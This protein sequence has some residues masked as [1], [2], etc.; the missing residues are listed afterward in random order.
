[1]KWLKKDPLSKIAIKYKLPLSFVALYLIVFGAGGYFIINSVNDSFDRE[2]RA[3]LQIE[4][5]AQ[6]AIFDK[7]LETFERRSEDFAS[8][9]FIRTQTEILTTTPPPPA[10]VLQTSRARLK[11]HL[12]H[13]KLPLISEFF[14]LQV[15]DLNYKKVVGILP[16]VL[17][18][19]KYLNLSSELNSTQFSTIIPPD[20]AGTFPAVAI[21]TPLWD[22]KRTHKI[23]YLVCFLNLERVIREL[24]A[25][26]TK[27][28]GGKGIEK[29]LTF[30]DQGGSRLEVPWWVLERLSQFTNSTVDNTEYFGIKFIKASNADVPSS[31]HGRHLCKNGKDMFGQSYPLHSSGWNVLI[32]VN[33]RDALKPIEIL[34]G[35]LLGVALVVAFSTLLLLFFPVQFV[36]RPLGELQKMAFRIKE[37]DFS[38]RIDIDSEDEIG[39]LARSF[40]LMAKAIEERTTRLEQTAR[41]LKKREQEL[42]IQHDRLNTVV[43]SMTD[44]LILL[45]NNNEIVLHNKAAEPFVHLLKDLNPEMMIRKC[46]HNEKKHE[47]CLTCL[48]DTTLR[49]SCVL[50]IGE[51]IYEVI[52][53]RLPAIDGASG[54]VLVARDITERERMNERQAHQERLA[55]LGKTAAV[56]AHEMNSPLAAIS[57]YNQ[58]MEAE[59]PE[60]SPFHEHVDVIKRNTLTCQRIIKQLL[61]YARIPQ[62]NIQKIDL[63]QIIENV[64]HFLHPV[65]KNKKVT[66]ETDFKLKT[67]TILGDMTQLQQVFVNL[68]MNA[69]QAV[70]AETGRVQIRTFSE[71][72]DNALIIEVEDNGI[73][74]EDKYKN[75]ILEPFFTI[76]K[77][78]G[79]GLGLS[80]AKRIVEA[81]QGTLFLK[82]SQPGKTVFQIRLPFS[83]LA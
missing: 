3:R 55:V 79:T 5:L 77:P 14:D 37:G 72:E 20:S 4:S 2:I 45:N 39:N 27:A 63:H 66:L 43:N 21:V 1:M 23:G 7:K 52:T 42:R 53:T 49:T 44:G 50:T 32:E 35:N 83:N 31:H 11:S 33:A 51:S 76:K 29:S 28:Q 62:P 6:A 57:M 10:T 56:V 74:I 64:V 65:C 19:H 40:N 25:E 71:P 60:D 15:L 30:I 58:M 26:Y 46:D 75:E 67:S 41:D 78:G 73:G 69:I 13:N 17:P 8:D 36:I 70:P 12:E 16:Q 22:I 34:E 54:K 80:T 68:I 38:A 61:D 48:L 47:N 24:A 82:F 81:H 9:G 59:L 18:L